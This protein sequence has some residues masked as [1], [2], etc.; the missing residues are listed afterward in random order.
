[1]KT[2]QFVIGLKCADGTKTSIATNSKGL[3]LEVHKSI[4]GTGLHYMTGKVDHATI[5]WSVAKEYNDSGMSPSVTMNNS[6]T[7]LEVHKASHNSA[8]FYHL[9]KIT[10]NAVVWGEKISFDAG[11]TP[12]VSLDDMGRAVEVHRS[13]KDSGL[14]CHV[15][16]LNGNS[17]K[18]NDGRQFDGGRD[19]SVE[20]NN[21]GTILE[22]H[23]SGVDASLWYRIGRLDGMGIEWNEGVSF[24]QGSEPSVALTDDNRVLVVYR[25]EKSN[26]LRQ[27]LCQR[28]GLV[29][30]GAIT[31]SSEESFFDEGAY[32]SV[33]C[34]G[35]LAVETH[36][37]NR[38][39]MIGFSFSLLEDRANWMRDNFDRL[40]KVPLRELVLP[41]SGESA[42][43]G[44]GSP[45]RTQD[46]SVYDQLMSGI[47]FLDISTVWRGEFFTCSGKTL[48][49]KLMNVIGEIRRFIE[50][51]PELVLVKITDKSSSPED[52]LDEFKLIFGL[53]SKWLFSTKIANKRL[54]DITLEEYL[55][56]GF[57]KGTV[58]VLLNSSMSSNYYEPW[59]WK[60]KS[61][62][63]KYAL[64][65]D[66]RVY[67]SESHEYYRMEAEEVNQYAHY[68][69]KCKEDDCQCDLFMLS[70]T[71][72]ST[73]VMWPA[74]RMPD[75]DLGECS[76]RRMMIPN[77]KG[78]IPNLICADY[79]EYARV[80][81]IALLH[82]RNLNK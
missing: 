80:T 59:L 49:P 62:N 42:M 39:N 18:W 68:D 45:V 73:G 1:M 66:M 28:T 21:N 56:A 4:D 36:G 71:L 81:D 2:V 65:G 72:P 54:A 58:L 50:D 57:G 82:D 79:E 32:P 31:W 17:V 8:L 76:S 34:K 19:P 10:E 75:M 7:A 13:E 11:E 70:W 5:L 77:A 46:M 23:Q 29:E 9:G 44:E 16:I 14:W 63:S 60:Y 6:G 25:A 67:D 37:I 48:G 3:F 41:A 33:A 53:I 30:N 15:G 35:S 47:R 55:N 43:Y 27:N 74:S 69:G 38:L 40:A 24:G 12:S 52:H 26:K 64:L 22:V 61:W 20:M 51:H 78:F